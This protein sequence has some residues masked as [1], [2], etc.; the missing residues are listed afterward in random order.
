MFLL[1]RLLK[2]AYITVLLALIALKLVLIIIMNISFIII[3]VD[4]SGSMSKIYS[5]V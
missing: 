5:T 4:I 1:K 3:D 2:V